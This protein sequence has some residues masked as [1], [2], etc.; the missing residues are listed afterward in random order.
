MSSISILIVEDDVSISNLLKDLLLRNAYIVDAAYSG[1]E[2]LFYLEKHPYNLVL[3]DLMLPG[4][5]GEEVL[6]NVRK[7]SNTLIIAISAKDDA[8]TKINLLKGG[9]DDYITKPFN[10]EELLAR[11]EALLRRNSG[12][13]GLLDKVLT[14]KD[15]KLNQSTYEVTLKDTLLSLTKREYKILELLM[16]NPHRVFSKNI[17]YEAVWDDIFLGEDN[18]IN[19][20]ISNL[21]QKLAKIT[22]DDTYIQTVWGIGFK[23]E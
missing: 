6:H 18:A 2:A 13:T 3:L 10:N 5:T 4:I 1:T 15:L 19:V 11:I 7:N 8:A 12:N 9:A 21:R 14:Y 20:H 22:P 23:M 16:G 17:I